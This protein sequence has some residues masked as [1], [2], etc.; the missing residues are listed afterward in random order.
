MTLEIFLYFLLGTFSGVLAGLFG[1]GGGNSKINW[2]EATTKN[3][4]TK[5]CK[6][7]LSINPAVIPPKADP[8][9]MLG[10]TTLIN[11]QS[12]ASFVLWK[13]VEEIELNTITPNELPSTMCDKI[14][15]AKPR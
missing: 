2:T 13:K 8:I 3:N 11:F 4:A 14:W 9:T 15:S 5:P 1:I 7:S 12:T 6:V 10:A